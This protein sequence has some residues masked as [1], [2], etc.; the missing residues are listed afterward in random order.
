MQA[1]AEHEAV[2]FRNMFPDWVIRQQTS[3]ESD[4]RKR[5]V[6]WWIKNTYQK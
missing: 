4:L 6:F 2:R 3:Q 1:S 5:I